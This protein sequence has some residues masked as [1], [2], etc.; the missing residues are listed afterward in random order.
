[1]LAIF[2]SSIA[3]TIIFGAITYYVTHPR[4]DKDNYHN[5]PNH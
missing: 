5:K 1:M 4:E 3:I 2:L